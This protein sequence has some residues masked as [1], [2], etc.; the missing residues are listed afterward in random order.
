MPTARPI[1]RNSDQNPNLY[2]KVEAMP[3][4]VSGKKIGEYGPNKLTKTASTVISN[5]I[6]DKN[7]KRQDGVKTKKHKGMSNPY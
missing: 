5:S 6:R 7:M 4:D 3:Y 2:A 1:A